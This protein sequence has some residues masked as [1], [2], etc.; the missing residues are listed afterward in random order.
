[1]V[2]KV[3]SAMFLRR[4]N[5]PVKLALVLASIYLMYNSWSL[6]DLNIRHDRVNFEKILMDFL[7]DNDLV[8]NAEKTKI[9]YSSGP[10]LVSDLPD[11]HLTFNRTGP[12]PE[13]DNK[14]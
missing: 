12:G 1:M 3:I 6:S 8:V 9:L 7:T 11:P 10:N 4:G 5:D 14:Q 2:S 13:L